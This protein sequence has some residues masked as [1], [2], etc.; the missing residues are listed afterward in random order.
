MDTTIK[1]AVAMPTNRGLK[2]KTLQSLLELVAYKAYN[3]EIIIGTEGFNTAENRTWLVAQASKAGC[4]HIFCVDDDM[5]YEKDTLEKLLSH[6]KDIV[7]ARYANRRGTGEV[8]EYLTEDQTLTDGKD[9]DLIMV[10]ALGGGCVLIKMDVFTKVS[11]PWFWYKIAPT[12]AV[13]MSHDWYFCEKARDA[14]YKVWC[15]LSIM[16]GHI[17]KKEF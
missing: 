14:G 12:G 17:G 5:V 16:P 10:N 4:T 1:I 15:D 3:Y 6:D 8:V 9:D 11:Q 13:T 7:G 2:P